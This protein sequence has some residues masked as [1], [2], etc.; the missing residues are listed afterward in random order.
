MSEEAKENKGYNYEFKDSKLEFGIDPNKDGQNVVVGRVNLNEAMQEIIAK[1][2]AKEGVKVASFRFEITKLIIELDSDKD[3]EKVME[4]EIDIA[5][6][7]DESG[8][9]K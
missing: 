9:M 8:V 7:L 5:E 3:G 1:G 4:I 2:E 6:A